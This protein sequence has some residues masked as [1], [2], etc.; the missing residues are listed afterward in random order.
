MNPYN[1]RM[2]TKKIK[3]IEKKSVVKYKKN[4]INMKR[5]KKLNRNEIRIPSINVII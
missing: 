3:S 4:G 2:K 5:E 1:R